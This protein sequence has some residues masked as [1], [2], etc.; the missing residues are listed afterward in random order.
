M[1]KLQ[2]IERFISD[3]SARGIE[4]WQEA[5]RLRFKGPKE[6]LSA[7]FIATLKANKKA[8]LASV[9]LSEDRERTTKEE[10]VEESFSL[11]SSQNAIWMI[12][13]LLPDNP[14]YNTAFVAKLSDQRVD[15]D[16]A[17]QAIKWVVDR[18]AILRTTFSESDEGASQH[19][20]KSLE[21][22]LQLVNGADWTEQQ[23][24]EYLEK[25]VDRP[26]DLTK[27][28]PFRIQFVSHPV[29]GDYLVTTI[30]HIAADLW[31]LIIIA[32]EFEHFYL[33]TIRNEVVTLSSSMLTYRD[34]VDWQQGFEGTKQGV[35]QQQYWGAKLANAR[36]KIE[37]P[38]DFPRPETLQSRSG[39]YSCRIQRDRVQKIRAYC[40]QQGMTPFVFLQACYQLLIFKFTERHDFLVGTP[41]AGRNKK[42]MDT[43]V[44]DFANPVALR[45][46]IDLNNT[47]RE[48]FNSVKA[49]VLSSLANQ[50]LPF[51][52]VVQ[53]C[54][55][56]RDL[57]RTPLFQHMFVWHQANQKDLFGEGMIESVH[58]LSGPRGAPYDL[59]LAIV[60]ASEELECNWTYQ[61]S[62]FKPETV[63]YFHEF[64]SLLIDSILTSATES[65]NPSLTINAALDSVVHYLSAR[66]DVLE[67][68]E[69]TMNLAIRWLENELPEAA[70]KLETR[71][72]W[73]IVAKTGVSPVSEDL[74]HVQGYLAVEL[75]G[76][77]VS[78]PI[79]GRRS[80]D[81]RFILDGLVDNYLLHNNE[82]VNLSALLPDS[83]GGSFYLIN[84]YA[85]TITADYEF[86]DQRKLN[87]SHH[88]LFI[89][90]NSKLAITQQT[91]QYFLTEYSFLHQVV[92]LEKFPTNRLG[93]IDRNQLQAIPGVNERFLVENLE[94]SQWAVSLSSVNKTSRGLN[95][96]KQF[97]PKKINNSSLQGDYS[98]K[99]KGIVDSESSR[100]F[101]QV[102]GPPLNN[103]YM[104]AVNLVSGLESTAKAHPDKG[105]SFSDA[106]LNCLDL[107]Y[108][109]LYEEALRLGVVLHKAGVSQS[110]IVVIQMSDLRQ[111]IP[112]WWGILIAG[113]KPLTVAVAQAFNHQ[114][115]VAV[116]L[117]NVV[118]S[119]PITHL[120]SGKSIGESVQAWLCDDSVHFLDVEDMANQA[121]LTDKNQQVLLCERTKS[122]DPDTTAFLQLT[123]GSTGTPKAIQITHAGILH[124][125]KAIAQSN[126]QSEADI[127]LNWLPF[128]HVVP[129]LTMHLKDVLL[130]INQVQLN[131]KDVLED[132]LLWLRAM[133]RFSV[134][135][136]WCPN[137][138][139]QLVADALQ[140]HDAELECDLSS[141]NYLMNAGEQVTE[142]IIDTFNQ[143]LTPFGLK[144]DVIQPAFGMAESCTCITYNNQS[145]KNRGVYTLQR[146]GVHELEVSTLSPFLNRNSGAF[147]DLGGV[148]PGVEIRIA[149]TDN[150]TLREGEIG[151]LQIRGPVVTPG[152][153]NNEAANR[154]SILEDGWFNSG[155]LGFIWQG[156]LVL[157]GR[158]KE[159][160]LIRGNNYYCYDIEHWVAETRGI[161]RGSVAA[162]C[163]LIEQQE[164]LVIFYV[165][166]GQLT[167]EDKQSLEQEISTT[168][169]KTFGVLPRYI[170]AVDSADFHK[171]TSGKIQRGQFKKMFAQGAYDS[172]L[173]DYDM[174]WGKRKLDLNHV[175][176]LSQYCREVVS[177]NKFDD[178]VKPSSG[179][180][181]LIM[182]SSVE[183]YQFRIAEVNNYLRENQAD[184]ITFTFTFLEIL[185]WELLV[186]WLAGFVTELNRSLASNSSI[187]ENC[188][189]NLFLSGR[190]E[191][192]TGLDPFIQSLNAEQPLYYYRL[193]VIS[194]SLNGHKNDLL[195][196][197][198]EPQSFSQSTSYFV[199][200]DSA[201]SK[202]VVQCA[203]IKPLSN[204]D[205]NN[206]VQSIAA[207]KHPIKYG[208][209]YVITGGLGDLGFELCQTLADEFL[210][211]LIILGRR[212]LVAG[213]IQWQRL[214]TLK[215]LAGPTNVEYLYL[216][217]REGKF[218]SL[219]PEL[220]KS[221]SSLEKQSADAISSVDG[222]IHLAGALP[223][224]PIDEINSDSWKA[225]LA[226]K[227]YLA[228]SL[229]RWLEEINPRAVF[230]QFGS[231][232]SIKAG[233]GASQYGVVNALQAELTESINKECRDLASWCFH[234]S[235][236]PNK[237]L[238]AKLDDND[239]MMAEAS[240]FLPVD[241]A[242]GLDLFFALLSKDPGNYY[243]GMDSESKNISSLVD[244]SNLNWSVSLHLDEKVTVGID[245]TRTE[246][247]KPLHT[248]A[249]QR[250]S[251]QVVDWPQ[252]LPLNRDGKVDAARLEQ[253]SSLSKCEPPRNQTDIAL[254][255]LWG[256]VL[257]ARVDDIEANFFNVGGHSIS[258]T[259]LI[260]RINQ[261]FGLGLNLAVIFQ[262]PVLSKLSDYI[263]SECCEQKS[264][265]TIPSQK[266]DPLALTQVLRIKE[267]SLSLINDVENSE[268]TVILFP[269]SAGSLA[270]YA[271][272]LP[273]FSDST[274]YGIHLSLADQESPGSCPSHTI[275]NQA[276]RI[277]RLFDRWGLTGKPMVFI[278]WSMAGVLAAQ[279]Y[280]T[281]TDSHHQLILL[282]SAIGKGL[283]LFLHD[284]SIQFSLFALELGRDI[285]QINEINTASLI[286][287]KITLLTRSLAKDGIAV[288][289]P[290]VERWF[291]SF[292]GS[293]QSLMEFNPDSLL[294]GLIAKAASSQSSCH[295]FRAALHT[296]ARDDLGW[297]E[298][299]E[300]FHLVSINADHQSIPRHPDALEKLKVLLQKGRVTH[301]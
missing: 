81:D 105:I 263:D 269:S 201:S 160:I 141:I 18:H 43:V 62:L 241:V 284:E 47:L 287:E 252:G 85:T 184:S 12:Y 148:I 166:D 292:S 30:H 301:E 132:P 163:C 79:L 251:Q 215:A 66:Q 192:A 80:L 286:S 195:L 158:E 101:A 71:D 122:V 60:D 98:S 176:T 172:L 143:L 179:L 128:D 225:L 45:A 227:V 198:S 97:V 67:V 249:T 89:E 127:A 173:K 16:A 14:A 257:G 224:T 159:T 154:E 121:A 243:I 20:H 113:G 103:S 125:A 211:R 242:T 219:K 209:T 21:P 61:A 36:Y 25:E 258:A 281:L 213:S 102:S 90:N 42:G 17:R 95:S 68:S 38:A 171:T 108:K 50:D 206:R 23:L 274:V 297:A 233:G 88:T 218:E 33:K 55:P 276:D 193:V 157:T 196:Q 8:I 109:E 140:K 34:H 254:L 76:K 170:L 31:S 300:R 56:P 299:Y 63:A 234:W 185:P 54:N 259:Q 24:E 29:L 72:C 266:N 7:E 142:K 221:I 96:Y 238:A 147:V 39:F 235:Y 207:T 26:F 282:D 134:S 205:D 129:I 100:P 15:V 278:G 124:H 44:G 217:E 153:L 152:Y 190:R 82:I 181:E 288:S 226:S 212:S 290:E 146:N 216:D 149:D 86:E 169:S 271:H 48:H 250:V 247:F 35:E 264:R 270:G 117:K 131:T 239:L 202:F 110:S 283:P 165:A 118:A 236:W 69:W 262:Y 295:L 244:K 275:Q 280:S 246:V 231:V 214:H 180:F 175:F 2:D 261:S 3:Q 161:V 167:S 27:Q 37:M 64:W 137:F 46:Q 178:L 77:L 277:K 186:P 57:S 10:A 230:I 111:Y 11:S 52:Q 265:N 107:S 210:C 155:D 183:E 203:A 229:Y 13:R 253:E 93:G 156:R 204:S 144:K 130:G 59:M 285:A 133:D 294:P 162:T 189:I 51:P 40:R 182:G 151:R 268:T 70:K 99:S 298:M 104:K 267:D 41:A 106:E 245:A 83:A 188:Q 65:K 273:A 5:G 223:V 87:G 228:Q 32:K 174:R 237:G 114:D 145:S 123:S 91:K 78:L 289:E 232:N 256:Q 291:H 220:A 4:L 94:S 138:G 74:C 58:P 6:L 139:F 191:H 136:S 116:K 126:E 28:G 73:K 9:S 75:S 119:L 296:H 194:E 49:D 248:F 92:F 222:V 22:D 53:S 115:S 112:L 19:V 200:Q 197:L 293:I 150:K 164:A 84:R 208:G 255:D 187:P 177:Q 168:L 1:T 279:L 240:G 135:H 199:F 120:I 272:L 260:A